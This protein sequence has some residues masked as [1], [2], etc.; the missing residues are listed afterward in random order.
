MCL[1]LSGNLSCDAFGGGRI[2]FY[3]FGMMDEL[4]DFLKREF[5]NMLFGIYGND[6]KEVVDSLEAMDIIRKVLKSMIRGT[7]S[8]FILNL[9]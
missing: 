5:V 3:D 8:L 2:I 1:S 9:V 6:V 4:S 7:I